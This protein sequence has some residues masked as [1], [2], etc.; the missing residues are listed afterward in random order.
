[1]SES[2]EAETINV[3]TQSEG[4]D[5]QPYG[6][7]SEVPGAGDTTPPAAG[8]A[9]AAGDSIE[10]KT[11]DEVAA[12]PAEEADPGTDLPVTTGSVE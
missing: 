6:S 8:L 7:P 4:L 5:A 10:G 3:A 2:G 11:A 1:M 12:G 9:S